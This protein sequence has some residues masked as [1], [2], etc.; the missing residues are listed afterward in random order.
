[1]ECTLPDKLFS[2]DLY[3]VSQN[4]G[5]EQDPRWETASLGGTGPDKGS[6]CFCRKPREPYLIPSYCLKSKIHIAGG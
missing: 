1:M 6:G 2:T 4:D 5:E 3:L